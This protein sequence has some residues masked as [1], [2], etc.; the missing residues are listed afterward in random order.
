MSINNIA[1][2][3]IRE[4][5]DK[6]FFI[7]SYQRGYRWTEQQITDLLDDIDAFSRQTQD[8]QFY[9]LQPLVVREM[10]LEEKKENELTS[11][12]AWYEVIDGQQRLTTIFLILSSEAFLSRIREDMSIAA[13]YELKYQRGMSSIDDYYVG[14]AKKTIVEWKKKRQE[15]NLRPFSISKF[16]EALLLV[17]YPDEESKKDEANNV[18]FIWY[19]SVNEDPIKVFTRLNIGKISLTNGELIKALFLNRSHFNNDA[20]LKLRQQEIATEWDRIEYTLQKEDFWLFLNAINDNRPTRIELIF[21]LICEQDLLK[22]NALNTGID[23]YKTFRY[24]NEYFSQ[25]SASISDCW[26]CVKTYFNTFLEWYNNS[27][28]YHYVGFLL[29]VDKDNVAELMKKWEK[30]SAKSAFLETLK[31]EIKAFI[32]DFELLTQLKKEKC[33]GVLLFHNIQT[34]INRN[35]H[36]QK[37]LNTEVGTFYRFPFHLYKKESWDVEHINS[38]TENEETESDTREYSLLNFYL[39]VPEDVQQ[40]IKQYF[41]TKNIDEKEELYMKIKG[42]VTESESW[43][44]EEKN[45]IWNYAL[46]DSSTNRGYGNAIFSAKR[47]IIIGKDKGKFIPM[48]ILLKDGKLDVGEE[49]DACSSFVP[50]CTL[51]VFMK[52]YSPLV[53]DNNYWTKID[54]KAY[55]NDIKACIKQLEE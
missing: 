38:N 7:P 51:L 33:R 54:A 39:S 25:K 8:H 24:F 1:L 37:D 18:R 21:D 3:S 31:K 43:T 47:K 55:L 28:L 41:A 45:Q 50:L 35:L 11:E 53:G 49:K 40:Q 17:Y 52:Y 29:S 27:Q 46:L 30:N 10:S 22:I 13:C 32:G 4:I 36:E 14:E 9:C 23:E 19:E 42:S 48:P 26:V 5:L 15:D 20:A 16:C 2:K 34:A 12:D 6:K 44:L